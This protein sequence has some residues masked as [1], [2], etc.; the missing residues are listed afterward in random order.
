MVKKIVLSIWSNLNRY[1]VTFRSVQLSRRL[2]RHLSR[3]D[4]PLGKISRHETASSG[5]A[6]SFNTEPN[7]HFDPTELPTYRTMERNNDLNTLKRYPKLN[8]S[9]RILNRKF[10]NSDNLQQ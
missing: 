4:R 2:K 9:K 8:G 10:N 1:V 5:Q 7:F 3:K 6:N